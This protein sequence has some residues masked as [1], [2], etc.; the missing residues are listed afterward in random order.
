MR[1]FLDEAVLRSKAAQ[2]GRTVTRQREQVIIPSIGFTCAGSISTWRFVAERN[3][4]SRRSRYPQLQIWRPQQNSQQMFD[5]VQS[6]TVTPHSTAQSNVYTHTMTTSIQYQA[7]DVLGLHHPSS[8]DSVYDIY[9]VQHGG[10]ENYHF[11]TR[12]SSSV[13][14]DIQS[15]GVR[16]RRDYP[17]VGVETG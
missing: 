14:F 5:L 3:T 15:S 12:E 2:I 16:V 9:S 8:D 10:P 11:S 4:G 17:L 1:G 6:V 13:Q 7:G